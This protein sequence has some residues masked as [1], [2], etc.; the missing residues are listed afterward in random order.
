MPLA[1]NTIDDD[2]E[3]LIQGATVD[4]AGLVGL[5]ATNNETI[6]AYAVG[7]AGA[8]ATRATANGCSRS[9][10]PAPVRATRSTIRRS[11]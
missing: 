7:V 4:S 2:T 11:P 5:S 8:L 9:R 10:G 1:F 6:D 3:A